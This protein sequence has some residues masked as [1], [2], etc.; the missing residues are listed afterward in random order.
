MIDSPDKRRKFRLRIDNPT[1]KNDSLGERERE[2]ERERNGVG[3]LSGLYE[4][5]NREGWE[6]IIICIIYLFS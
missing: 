6:L 4:R 5:V 2:R 1:D 3:E